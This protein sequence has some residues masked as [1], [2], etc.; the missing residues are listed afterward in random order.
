MVE[1]ISQVCSSLRWNSREILVAVFCASLRSAQLPEEWKMARVVP[2]FKKGVPLSI[3]NYP[4]ISLTSSC[5]KV[6]EH[7]ICHCVNEYLEEHSIL[8]KFQHGFR[9]CH[10][11]IREL[12][13][14]THSL[15][16]ALDKKGRVDFIFLDFSKAFDKVPCNKLILKLRKTGVPEI[17]VCCFSAYLTDRKQFLDVGG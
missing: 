4:P 15:S 16:S 7:I 12:I 10:S 1:I 6:I 11:T 14:I 5:C 13:T 17:F 3:E 8:T 2:I 9:V